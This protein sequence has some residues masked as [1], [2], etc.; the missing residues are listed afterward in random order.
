MR[1]VSV[2]FGVAVL[3]FVA[4]FFI[5]FNAAIHG[6]AWKVLANVLTFPTSLIPA[7]WKVMDGA[8]GWV[9]WMLTSLAWGWGIC[10]LVRTLLRP[11]A[12]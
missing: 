11:A 2:V 7:S 1:F 3:H 12:T 4:T 10:A 5:G 9:A 8:L 6:G